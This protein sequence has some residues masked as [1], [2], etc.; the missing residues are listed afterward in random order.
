MPR[1][2]GRAGAQEDEGGGNRAGVRGRGRG[3]GSPAAEAQVGMRT[4]PRSRCPRPPRTQAAVLLA[5][6][7]GVAA[8]ALSSRVAC[9]GL[10]WKL[11]FRPQMT[12]RDPFGIN[13]PCV[14][15]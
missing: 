11:D 5:K 3:L 4:G 13:T 1:K 2:A 8:E 10:S 15:K 14:Q 12:Y 7:V 9:L 6:P